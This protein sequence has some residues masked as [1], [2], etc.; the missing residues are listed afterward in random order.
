MLFPSKIRGKPFTVQLDL[1]TACGTCFRVGCP[2]ISNST[3]KNEK[4]RPKSEI[5][6]GMCTGCTICAQVCPSE[7]IVEL[8]Q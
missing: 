7:A 1:C 4:G 8:Q 3:E 5:D 2:A 6:P